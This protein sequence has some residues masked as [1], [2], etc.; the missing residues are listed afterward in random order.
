MTDV[1]SISPF[2]CRMWEMHDRMGEEITDASCGALIVSLRRHGQKQAALGSRCS[3]TTGF[4]IEL[5][6]GA[7]RLFAAKHL[8]ISLLVEVR[9]LE[10]KA[11]LIEMDI[12]NRVRKDISP[13]ER[14]LS[15]RSWLRAG[16][17]SHQAEIAKCIGVSEA[18]V[19]RLLRYSELPAA[20]VEA[21]P[22][23]RE[24]REEWAVALAKRCQ[25]PL[26]RTS[27]INF[28]RR[29]RRSTDPMEAQ[30]VFDS[31]VGNGP[32]AIVQAKS[33]DEVFRNSLG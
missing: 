9:S 22:S 28:A 7:R 20:V 21:F 31:L 2:K 33:K 29:I 19:S 10:D 32:G 4:E 5:I 24:I 15:Y 3:P 16:Y 11:A 25:D 13:Y 26:S 12:E 18:Q 1:I 14:G 8:G 17:F 6:Y 27:V 30:R 23:P